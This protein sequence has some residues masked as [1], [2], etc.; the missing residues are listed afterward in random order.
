MRNWVYAKSV[1]NYEIIERPYRVLMDRH[2]EFDR[3]CFS[4]DTAIESLEETIQSLKR[5]VMAVNKTVS[6]SSA[7][8]VNIS[9][10]LFK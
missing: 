9:N 2:A 7:R 4:A 5:K 3:K 10:D 6:V 8:Y 1:V